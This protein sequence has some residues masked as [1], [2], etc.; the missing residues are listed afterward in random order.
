MNLHDAITK[1][2]VE[3][4]RDLA[5][6]QGKSVKVEQAS[7]IFDKQK[8]F[9]QLMGD[10][11]LVKKILRIFL[12]EAPGLMT[13]L[14]KSV[15]NNNSEATRAL[16]HKIAGTAGS[17]SAFALWDAAKQMERAAEKGEAPSLRLCRDE[18]LL[19][20]DLLKRVLEWWGILESS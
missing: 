19:Q 18:V 5:W 8:L 20:F 6:S 17:I 1:E 14:D 15:K 3:Y 7:L 12:E 10:T 4:G 11:Q 2:T 9:S 13:A 16:V